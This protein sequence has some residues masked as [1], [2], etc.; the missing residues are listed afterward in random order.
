VNESLQS[1]HSLLFHHQFDHEFPSHAFSQHGHTTSPIV[2]GN[3]SLLNDSLAT[4][5]EINTEGCI[6]LIEE[7]DE[8]LYKIDRMLNQLK[9]AGKLSGLKGVIIGDFSDMKDTQIPFGKGINDILTDYFKNLSI[10][11]AFGVP[12]G[13]ENRNLAIPL[14]VP[15]SMTVTD[16]YCRVSFPVVS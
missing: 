9:R 13:H 14:N 7:V 4:L 1:L 16:D 15:V 6:L 8:Y 2:G 11:V 5:T 10:P 3:L 12:V